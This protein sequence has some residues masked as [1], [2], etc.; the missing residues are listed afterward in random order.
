MK[1]VEIA[2]SDSGK[3]EFRASEL[4]LNLVG[5]RVKADCI[6]YTNLQ[7]YFSS[8]HMWHVFC[9]LETRTL[10]FS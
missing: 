1:L 8:G 10:F 4:T 3:L 6:K 7:A 2:I 5:L 9:H